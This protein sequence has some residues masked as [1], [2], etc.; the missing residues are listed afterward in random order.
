MPE[1]AGNPDKTYTRENNNVPSGM[2]GKDV[3]DSANIP[4]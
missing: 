4:V 3:F 2:T 1:H